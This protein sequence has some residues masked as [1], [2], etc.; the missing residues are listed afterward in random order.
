MK[1]IN[2]FFENTSY[3]STISHEEI[4][5]IFQEFIDFG[6]KMTISEQYKSL[7]T[8]HQSDRIRSKDFIPF[9]DIEFHKKFKDEDKPI[10]QFN[11]GVYFEDN[12][13]ELES[14]TEAISHL[15]SDIEGKAK[16]MYAWRG[17]NNV[18]VRISEGKS[19]DKVNWDD[20]VD[21][22][23]RLIYDELEGKI[24][25]GESFKIQTLDGIFDGDQFGHS[26]PGAALTNNH[27]S[28]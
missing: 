24:R 7:K 23:N 11:G 19:V 15:Q 14:L 1:Y 4:T 21:N 3:H 16:V 20:L 25:F 12:L 9:T 6:Y 8:R 27:I 2:K 18:I 28:S 17:S 22:V 13:E 26:E 5:N 10:I